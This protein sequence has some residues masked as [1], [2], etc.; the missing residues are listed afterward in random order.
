MTTPSRA[1]TTLDFG[2]GIAIF[3]IAI[4]F[5]IATVSTFAAPYDGTTTIKTTVADTTADQFAESAFQ[6]RPPLPGEPPTSVDRYCVNQFF[7]NRSADGYCRYPSPGD[8]V[9]AGVS[10]PRELSVH[11][12]IETLDGTV[13]TT[14]DTSTGSTITYQT[15]PQPEADAIS[16]RVI[17][18]DT[19]QYILVVTVT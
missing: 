4:V 16:R 14:S 5:V 7:Q 15:G 11:V 2:L 3:L 6:A 18:M 12:Q 1:Q 8:S 10:P 17:L 9:T 19:Q 13:V